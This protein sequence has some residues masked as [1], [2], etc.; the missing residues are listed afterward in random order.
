MT[1]TR[2][3]TEGPFTLR[4]EERGRGW[5][6]RVTDGRDGRWR[7]GRSSSDAYAL[8]DARKAVDALRRQAREEQAA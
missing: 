7:A 1:V 2:I 4:I 8:H 5:W 3:V 6:W